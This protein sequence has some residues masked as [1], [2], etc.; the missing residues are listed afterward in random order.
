MMV[1]SCLLTGLTFLFSHSLA[2]WPS[3]QTDLKYTKED[4]S[5]KSDCVA[6]TYPSVS[7]A[8][9]MVRA[10][11]VSPST[12]SSAV[13]AFVAELSS[14]PKNKNVLIISGYR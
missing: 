8:S 12:D 6:T 14:A 2:H 5:S 13:K 4:I 10:K 3:P 9:C 1:F 11:N 7:G